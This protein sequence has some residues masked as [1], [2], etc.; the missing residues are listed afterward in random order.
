[1]AELLQQE[2][3]PIPSVD[4]E[5]PRVG[6]GPVGFVVLRPRG[7][8][9][10]DGDAPNAAGDPSSST[11]ISADDDARAEWYGG[12]GGRASIAGS[13]PVPKERECTI[14]SLRQRDVVNLRS[15]E[16]PKVA[17]GGVGPVRPEVA[18]DERPISRPPYELERSVGRSQ[19]ALVE[20][21]LQ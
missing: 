6:D 1:M 19:D 21:C 14:R 3:R 15:G 12:L 7:D 16:E 20:V 13:N 17:D 5:P 18:E 11:T 2:P 8:V 9:V 10:E 4:V